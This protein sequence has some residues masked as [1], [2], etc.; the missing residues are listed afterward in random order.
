MIES[1]IDEATIIKDDF[2]RLE[3]P[4]PEEVYMHPDLVDNT[5]N[6]LRKKLKSLAE[7]QWYLKN[8][9]EQCKLDMLYSE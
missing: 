9:L 3:V 5:K 4:M 2:R 1:R 6:E 8:E 7:K